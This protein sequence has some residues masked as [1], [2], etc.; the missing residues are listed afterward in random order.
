MNCPSQPE[1]LSSCKNMWLNLNNFKCWDETNVQKRG[2]TIKNILL[3]RGFNPRPIFCS[4][5]MEIS[6]LESKKKSFNVILILT[7]YCQLLILSWFWKFVF[8]KQIWRV[9]CLST[10]EP[11]KW[12]HYYVFLQKSRLCQNN[13]RRYVYNMTLHH[14]LQ[15][16]DYYR[17]H[18]ANT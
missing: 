8:L 5:H 1:R 18:I 17:Y 7:S 4:N 3:T 6:H 14:S 12:P 13:S 2:V 16:R 10:F 15:K 9:I 11:Q